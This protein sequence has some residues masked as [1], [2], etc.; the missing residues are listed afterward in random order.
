[1]H[2]ILTLATFFFLILGKILATTTG[3]RNRLFKGV[4]RPDSDI[5][6]VTVGIKHV[7]FWTLVGSQLHGHKGVLN[8]ASE[9][10]N[11]SHGA[12]KTML[13]VMFGKVR[14]NLIW[15][16][17][18]NLVS[19]GFDPGRG[20]GFFSERENSERRL[21][22]YRNPGQSCINATSYCT[23]S[24][25]LYDLLFFRTTLHLLGPPMETF[26]YGKDI[27]FKGLLSKPTLGPF[28]SW[29]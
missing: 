18:S 14:T 10:Q 15:W 16:L 13:S 7:K 4:F 2:I 9:G 21:P 6:F 11:E 19:H 5:H 23:L 12:L 3:Y 25:F 20:S 17:T 28:T 26:M 22:V 27:F 8:I 24:R 1:M 29:H